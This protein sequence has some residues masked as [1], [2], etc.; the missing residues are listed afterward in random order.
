MKINTS[1]KILISLLCIGIALVG[2][3][4][5]LPVVFRQHDKVLHSAFY[6]FAAAFFNILFNKKNVIVHL[7]IFGLLYGFG[8]CIEYAQAYSN[9]FFTQKIHGRY[10]PEDILAN[11]RGL[12]LFTAIWVVVISIIQLVTVIKRNHKS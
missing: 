11:G 1:Y 7:L 5:K 3:M 9:K 4:L 6:F 2:F 8:I 10:D 12:L